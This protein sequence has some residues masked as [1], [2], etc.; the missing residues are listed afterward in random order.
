[1]GKDSRGCN[2]TAMYDSCCYHIVVSPESKEAIDSGTL[3]KESIPFFYLDAE[4]KVNKVEHKSK[5][6]YVLVVTFRTSKKHSKKHDS[7]REKKHHKGKKH[8]H[9]KEK[10]VTKD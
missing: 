2:C 6:F 7:R 8:D 5:L 4:K 9:K 3:S 1:M 10:K